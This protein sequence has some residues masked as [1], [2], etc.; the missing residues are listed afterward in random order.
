MQGIH[1]KKI[2]IKSF[3]LIGILSVI[4]QMGTLAFIFII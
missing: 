1:A 2:N 3:S 4:V